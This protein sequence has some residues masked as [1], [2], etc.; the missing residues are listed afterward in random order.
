EDARRVLDQKRRQDA[1]YLLEAAAWLDEA[2]PLPHQ[3]LANVFAMN[4]NLMLA[5]RQMRLALDRDP[6]NQLYERNLQSLRRALTRRGQRRMQLPDEL[7]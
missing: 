6:G 5:L 3:Y 4:G 1:I 2:S 7:P